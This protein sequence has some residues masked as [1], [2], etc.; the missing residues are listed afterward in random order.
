MSYNRWMPPECSTEL[1]HHGVKGMKWGKHLFG[2][3]V[4]VQASGGG[5]GGGLLEEEPDDEELKEAQKEYW[6][7]YNQ[8]HGLKPEDM[9]GANAAKA[10]ALFKK[11][12][13]SLDNLKAKEA[14]YKKRKEAYE[15]SVSYKIKHPVETA[16]EAINKASSAVSK[17][18]DRAESK[19]REKTGLTAREQYI[20][21]KKRNEG[22]DHVN[23]K[24]RDDY[25]NRRREEANKD[26]AKTKS[27]YEKTPLGKAASK[28]E[29]GKNKIK[30]MLRKRDQQANAER[31]Q[32][33]AHNRETF[34]RD[35]YRDNREYASMQKQE[36]ARKHYSETHKTATLHKDFEGKQTTMGEK[37]QN[38][39]S[40]PHPNLPRSRKRNVTGKGTGV[41]IGQTV[42]PPE[43][44]PLMLIT[45]TNRPTSRKR[46]VTGKGTGVHVH[47]PGLNGGRKR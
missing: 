6:D 24:V 4:E 32:T 42:L 10:D 9:S 14:D 21:A 26:V 39:Q 44:K 33:K 17:K 40:N 34:K 1:Y 2:K 19:I 28:I 15:Q 46:K 43:P 38:V 8:V 35:F 23:W 18:I 27:E 25:T 37:A 47:G 29:S 12:Y 41:H 45:D 3:G 13:E 7:L 30:S 11:Y 20:G 5:G 16:S 36:S 22:F 31:R